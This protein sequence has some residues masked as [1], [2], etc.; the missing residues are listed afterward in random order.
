[1]SQRSAQ[2]LGSRLKRPTFRFS[3][4]T[5]FTL[6]GLV[7]TAGIIIILAYVL[8][9][10]LVQ[11][12]LE[13]VAS[14]TG[15]QADRIIAPNLDPADLTALS[16]DRFAKLDDLIRKELIGQ[17]ILRVRIWNRQGVLVYTD[18]KGLVGQAF[19]V[20]QEL[21]QALGGVMA[22]DVSSLNKSASASVLT[23]NAPRQF[24]IYL[25]I[26][27]NSSQVVGAYEITHDADSVQARIDELQRLVYGSVVASFVILYLCLYLLVR[28]ASHELSRRTA[29]NAHLFEEEQTRRQELAALYDLSRTLSDTNEHDYILDL[30]ARRAVETVRVAF[31]RVGILEANEL[32]IRAGYPMR[33]FEYALEIGHH[34]PIAALLCLQHALL[35]EPLVLRHDSP[36]LTPHEREVLFLGSTKTLCVVPLR[37]DDLKLGWLLLNETRNPEREPFTAEKIRLARG[38]GDQA[39]SALHR[40]SLYRQTV[41]NAAELALAYDATIEGWSRALDLRDKET[42][43]HTLRVTSMTELLA[44]SIG[45]DSGQLVQV[46][47]GALLHDIGKMAIP[48]SI[49]LKPGP[50]TAEETSIMRKHPEYAFELLAPI[51][52]LRPALDIPHFHH[53]KY[54]GTG[55]PRRLTGEQIPLAARMF[56]V[57]DVWD[58]LMSDRPYRRAWPEIR[59]FQHIRSLSGT[60]FDPQSVEAFFQVPESERTKLRLDASALPRSIDPFPLG[61]GLRLHSELLLPPG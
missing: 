36:S 1:V 60:H 53:E 9:E 16:P 5:Q 8:R 13:D 28:H 14:A 10:R 17:Q 11:N 24:E 18:Q 51:S 54:D 58:A 25:P 3:L 43:G 4:L 15:E 29:E 40:A 31:A 22:T 47:R 33:D 19:A 35:T 12:A 6:L 39:G 56:A 26:R 45:M 57:V 49:L 20:S 34:E 59:V 27:I 2:K 55:Y 42:E 7:L 30:I 46:R 48:D 38:I 32:V 23:L 41:R 61:L 21:N 37:V 52:Y 44:R 50:L